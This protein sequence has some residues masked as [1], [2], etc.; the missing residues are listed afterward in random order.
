VDD[1]WGDSKKGGGKK[2]SGRGGGGGKGAK[3]AGATRDEPSATVI[4]VTSETLEEWVRATEAV[5]E[6]IME[7]VVE[8][9]GPQ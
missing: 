8:R 1:D 7:D 6:E 2:K 4:G 9:I 3:S 5:P